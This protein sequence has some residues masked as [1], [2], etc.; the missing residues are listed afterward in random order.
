MKNGLPS[1]ARPASRPN[2]VTHQVR[3]LK[4]RD[5]ATLSYD[6]HDYTDPWTTP[7]TVILQHGFGRSGRFWYGVIPALAR[8]YRVACPDFR[9]LGASTE[10]VDL[11]HSLTLDNYLAD[12]NAI[13]DD[14]AVP[15]LHLVGESLGGVVGFAFAALQGARLRTLT[16]LSSPLFIKPEVQRAF[17]FGHASWEQALEKMGS[18]EWSKQANAATR[19]PADTDPRIP[20]WFAQE[21]GQNRVEA[22]MAMVRF[23]SGADVTP[24]LERISVP[25]LG[26]YPT[27]G[28]VTS[29]EQLAVMREKIRDLRII[30]L[31]TASHMTWILEPAVCARHILEFI[32]AHD[33]SPRAT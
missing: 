32:S 5:G 13:V 18:C 33:G 6:I 19:F 25:V 22:L 14:L 8:H 12:L 15:S 23:A 27:A 26:L 3:K 1:C 20:A 11:D 31:A 10:G 16:T 30:H 28:A 29:D 4:A 9:G 7:S 24:L 21:S 17:A 2:S